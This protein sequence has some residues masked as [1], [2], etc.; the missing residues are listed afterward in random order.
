[1]T[2]QLTILGC[3]SAVPNLERFTTAQLLQIGNHSYL[4]DC[5]EGTQIRLAQYGRHLSKINQIFISH[6]HGD[7]INGLIGWITS[8]S[9]KGRTATLDIFSPEGL[10]EMIEVQLKWMQAHL[11]YPIVYHVVDTTTSKL[12]FEDKSATVHSIPLVHRIPT[13]GYLFREK[14]LERNIRSE[15]IQEYNISYTEIKEIKSGRDFFDS[16]GNVIPNEELLLPPYKPRSFAFCSDTL[17]H[18]AIVP[19]IYGVDLLYHETTFL[20]NELERALATKHTTAFQAGQIA[21]AAK[22]GKLITGH[23]SSRYEDVNVIAEEAR[24]VFSNVVAG[25][26]G[27]V[28]EVAL[29]REENTKSYK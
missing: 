14:P 19:L 24:T 7:H 11:T 20:H 18:E 23:Y 4:I 12:I 13:T 21:E 29:T 22:V 1:M 27:Q 26:D 28:Y 5:G 17:Y 3:N 9:L 8:L 2:F 15:K 6:L 10:Q 25:M 16:K